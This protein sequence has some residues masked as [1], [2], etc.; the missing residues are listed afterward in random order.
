MRIPLAGEW[1][2]SLRRTPQTSGG[3]WPPYGPPAVQGDVDSRFRGNDGFCRGRVWGAG[4]GV[5]RAGGSG[6]RTGP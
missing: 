6:E 1:Q 2:P 4:G 5:N 3:G